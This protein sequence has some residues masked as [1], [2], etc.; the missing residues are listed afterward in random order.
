MFQQRPG[1]KE[2]ELTTNMNVSD[3]EDSL[4]PA[5]CCSID[6]ESLCLLN[7]DESLENWKNLLVCNN[8]K[9]FMSSVLKV[10]QKIEKC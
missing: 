2:D 3:G 7:I 1:D 9:S 4:I 8:V 10:D 6:I 5:T